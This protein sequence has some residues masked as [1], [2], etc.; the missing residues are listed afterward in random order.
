MASNRSGNFSRN[1]PVV[2]VWFKLAYTL[3]VCVL[4]PVYWATFGPTNFLWVSD[5]GLFVTLLALWSESRLLASMMA[6]GVLLTELAWNID[7]AVR[8]FFGSDALAIP[9][10]SYMFNTEI[11]ILVRSLSAFHIALPVILIWLVYRL[12]YER[13]ALLYQTLV[14]WA[15]LPATYLLTDPVANINWVYGFGSEPQT[16]MPGPLFVALLMVI[17][18]VVL[19]LPT[20]VLLSKLFDKGTLKQIP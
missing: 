7:F 14:A 4:I 10:T 17:V 9:G 11:P 2:T 18:P 19:Y 1:K 20:H 13:R 12:G 16:W 8:L 15:V 3:F 6:L 5:I